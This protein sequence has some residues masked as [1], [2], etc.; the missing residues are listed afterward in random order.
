MDFEQAVELLRG[1]CPELL[2][3]HMKKHGPQIK[4]PLPVPDLGT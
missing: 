1:A 3:C 4:K 2:F